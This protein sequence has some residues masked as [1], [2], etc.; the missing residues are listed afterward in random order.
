MTADDAFLS[1][2]FDSAGAAVTDLVAEIAKGL[3]FILTNVSSGS[4]STPPEVAREKIIAAQCLIA[5]C[6]KRSE[7]K[8][9][10]F[11]MPQAVQD[12]IGIAFGTSTP[13]IMLIEDGVE[14][15]GFKPNLGT[16]TIFSRN[17]LGDPKTVGS[18]VSALENLRNSVAGEAGKSLPGLKESYAEWVNHLVEMEPEGDDFI[19]KYSTAKRIIYT[20]TGRG[21]FPASV[22]ASVPGVIPE[23]APKIDWK[24]DVLESSNS[25]SILTQIQRHDARCFE[26]RLRMEPTPEAKDYVEFIS[27]ANS[28]YLNPIW[29]DEIESPPVHLDRGEFDTYDGLVFI[30]PTKQASV[31]FRFPRSYGLGPRDLLPFVGSFTSNID[32]EVQS[33]LERAKVKIE[34]FAG[35]LVARL[36]IANPLPNLFYGVAW[37]AVCRPSTKS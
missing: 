15:V 18:I 16:Y 30:H 20:Q 6:T 5:I 13:T 33:E 9:G 22:W 37:N 10:K 28:R 36:D 32:Y 27:Y 8:S 1:C 23:D 19:W 2:S 25:I 24:L 29:K 31:E 14:A 35:T 4:P 17:Q 12:E 7:L 26:A 3:G 21:S 34:E 11:H